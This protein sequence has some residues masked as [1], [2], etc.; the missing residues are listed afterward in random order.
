[1]DG[2]RV[3]A[4]SDGAV[5]GRRPLAARLPRTLRPALQR[6]PLPRPQD[7]GGQFRRFLLGRR[8][9]D[10]RNCPRKSLFSPITR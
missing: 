4:V 2:D 9:G 1:M 5:V 7:P 3:V 10:H 8:P 6:R